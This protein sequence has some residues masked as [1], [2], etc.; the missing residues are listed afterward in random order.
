MRL[1]ECSL[2]FATES[3]TQ[4]TWEARRSEWKRKIR[5]CG[6]ANGPVRHGKCNGGMPSILAWHQAK[7]SLGATDLED[8]QSKQCKSN[9]ETTSR[10]TNPNKQA[11]VC[12]ENRLR[13]DMSIDA[14]G[15]TAPWVLT[16]RKRPNGSVH[17][18]HNRTFSQ[19]QPNVAHRPDASSIT[20][21]P[22]SRPS[23]LRTCPR[24]HR[25]SFAVRFLRHL[26]RIVRSCRSPPPSLGDFGPLLRSPWGDTE[27]SRWRG[28]SFPSKAPRIQCDMMG[29]DCSG[30]VHSETRWGR[31]RRR[32]L[33]CLVHKHHA[34]CHAK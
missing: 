14:S 6:C 25:A 13:S 34:T 32:G 12:T 18:L 9:V 10:R 21:Q 19:L 33:D 11:R 23:W 28:V 29:S 17:D 22:V 7:R 30:S 20:K 26:R 15:N 3:A 27:A 8:G 1:G 5:A 2:V 31:D 4:C 16:S 24:L